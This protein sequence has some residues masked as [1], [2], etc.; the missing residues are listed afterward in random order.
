MFFSKILDYRS[1]MIYTYC[2]G[3]VKTKAIKD[4][5]QPD[6]FHSLLFILYIFFCLKRINNEKGVISE[7]FWF[8]WTKMDLV[9]KLSN[10]HH[11]S[12]PTVV[13]PL[14]LN[15]KSS[16]GSDAGWPTRAAPINDWRRE[17]NN[18]I[19]WR[20]HY[21]RKGIIHPHYSHA[22]LLLM[23]RTTQTPNPTL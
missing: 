2:K 16:T 6:I 14:P 17:T 1:K 7:L 4:K 21:C 11:A 20:R 18:C 9:V 13:K 10:Y 23:G 19:Q 12:V 5:W 22:R 8:R 3:V 15:D